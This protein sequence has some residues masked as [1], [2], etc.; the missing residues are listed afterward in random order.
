M[1]N[2][3]GGLQTEYQI[4]ELMVKTCIKKIDIIQNRYMIMV[5]HLNNRSNVMEEVMTVQ[6]YKIKGID[7]ANCAK[8]LEEEIG[9]LDGVSDCVLD[10]G[11]TS[12]LRYN[13]IEGKEAET[14]KVFIRTSEVQSTGY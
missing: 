5:E 12:H 9:K 7:C 4:Q 6:K 13:V 1:K 11:I 14:E 3:N 8:E 10:F 2:E